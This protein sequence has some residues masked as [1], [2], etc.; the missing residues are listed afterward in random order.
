MIAAQQKLRQYLTEARAVEDALTRVLEAQIAMTPRGE[1]RTALSA[2]LE[3]TRQHSSRLA[4]RLGEF[5]GGGRPLSA[6]VALMENI[7]GQALAL[8]KTPFDLLRGSGGEEK[9]LKNARDACASESLEIA[10]YTV[11]E[12]LA[13]RVGDPETAELAGAIRAEEER[14][15]AQII[16]VLPQ[17]TEAMVAAVDGDPS[18]DSATTGAG[19][20]VQDARRAARRTA[21]RAVAATQRFARRARRLPGVARLEG[22]VMGA[23]AGEDDLAIAHY[24]SLTVD[25]IAAKLGRLSQVDLATIDAYERRHQNRSTLTQRISTLRG[26]EPWPG[27]DE[28]TVTEIQAVLRAGDDGLA[29][30]VAAYEADHKN[31]AGVLKATDA[32]R[33]SAPAGA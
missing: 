8:G 10:M 23:L 3:E 26:T 5:S 2:H 21:G 16:G 11:I 32:D 18:Y 27:Y 30:R 20:A 19:E 24:D 9:V 14:M 4:Q 12:R 33:A 31:R 22:E 29:R 15:L 1:Y 13:R 7:T 28:L 25:E 6:A 17:L